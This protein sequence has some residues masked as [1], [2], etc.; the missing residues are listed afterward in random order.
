M[1]KKAHPALNALTTRLDNGL[2]I[3]MEP[4][5]YLHT[6]SAGLWVRAGSAQE[7]EVQSGLAHLLEHLFFKGTKTRS[8]RELMEAVEGRGGHLNAFTAREY[9]CLYVKTLDWHIDSA[10]EILADIL[11][12]STFSD[13]EKERNVIIEEIAS[14]EDTPDEY[15]HDLLTQY[16]W[17][18]H[19]LGRPVSGDLESVSRL[20]L[21]D[22][23]QFYQTWY[24]PENMF[25]SIAGNFDPDEVLPLIRKAFEQIPQNTKTEARRD[26][27]S[28]NGGIH[29]VPRDISQTHLALAFPGP[30]L[31]TRDRYYCDFA[32]SVLG[33]GSTSRLFER[34]REKEGLA[35]AIYTFQSFHLAAGMMGLYA[36]V[37]PGNCERT[38]ELVFEELQHLRD[39]TVP[40]DE[41]E[42]NREQIKGGLLM[43]ME[44]TFTR[45]AHMAKSM[46]YYGRIVPVEEIIENI[47]SV[48]AGDVQSFAQKAFQA[49]RCAL[50]TLG[51]AKNHRIKQIPL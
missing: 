32:G 34:I 2:T 27:P 13:L 30:M 26:A 38:I 43:A 24:T 44:S 23:R 11:I 14:I 7:Q 19:P 50:V 33:G 22:V 12:N 15:I 40:A 5:P 21:D 31:G 4:L 49:E 51:P 10:I 3:T 46:M 37:A 28:F 17:P 25:F 48:S 35:Y 9:T 29:Q 45:V 18:E 39:E 47:D 16:H 36:A 8:V 6:V 1:K 41:L 20:G 42:M